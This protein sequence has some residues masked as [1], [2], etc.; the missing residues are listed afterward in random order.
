MGDQMSV[1]SMCTAA[2][3]LP[4][5]EEKVLRV[6]TID[7]LFP[8]DIGVI[9][10][11]DVVTEFGVSVLEGE[12]LR[13]LNSGVGQATR[14]TMTIPGGNYGRGEDCRRRKNGIK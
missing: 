4:A 5:S 2:S 6:L 13:I 1:T 12:Q 3:S 11:R 8:E 14:T 10:F 7:G 9:R